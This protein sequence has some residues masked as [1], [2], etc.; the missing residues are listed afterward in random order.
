ME[1]EQDLKD[2]KLVSEA[3]RDGLDPLERQVRDVFRKIMVS[4]TEGLD[5]L[6]ASNYTGQ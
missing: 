6:G 1:V 4:R 3:F 2:L 5:V